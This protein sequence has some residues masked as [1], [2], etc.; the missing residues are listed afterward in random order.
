MP[1]AVSRQTAPERL[2]KCDLIGFGP[3]PDLTECA[4]ATAL[5]LLARR[6]YWDGLVV[7]PAVEE[8]SASNAPADNGNTLW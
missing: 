8:T 3:L 7:V 4:A 5:L 6:Y 1:L 2:K